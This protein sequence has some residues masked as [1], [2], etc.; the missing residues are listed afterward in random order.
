MATPTQL[1]EYDSESFLTW[2]TEELEQFNDSVIDFLDQDPYNL[3]QCPECYT[4]DVMND[5]STFIISG[6]FRESNKNPEAAIYDLLRLK[7]QA[8]TQLLFIENL[9][10][11]ADDLCTDED[12]VPND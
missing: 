6:V 2:V 5:L 10:V 1:K 8:Q 11:A 3:K 7:F 4:D 12:D 9:L